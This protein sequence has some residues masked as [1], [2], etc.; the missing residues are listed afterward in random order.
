MS[1]NSTATTATAIDKAAADFAA[2]GLELYRAATARAQDGRLELAEYAA[3]L[4][5]RVLELQ[6]AV[7]VD[8]LTRI[9]S[10]ANLEAFLG[11]ELSRTR[12]TLNPTALVALDLD[13]FK[14]VNDSLGHAVG[15]DVLRAV[16]AV[17]A[18]ETRPTDAAGRIG[19]E[20]FLVVLSGADELSAYAA[21]ERI[22]EAI[23]A[24]EFPSA[25]ELKVTASLGVHVERGADADAARA[26]L[27]ADS[28]LY[29]S[30]R[31]GR[32]RSTMFPS[33]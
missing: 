17:L 30:K 32:N 13:H 14:G 7:G 29:A 31:G 24:L 10:R 23:A 4:E 8:H 11:V 22:R 6:A 5:A 27:K 18:R 16:G 26:E 15:D 28:A 2:R 19:G 33:N 21:A 1:Q 3:Q 20:E 25:P 12:R 9:R